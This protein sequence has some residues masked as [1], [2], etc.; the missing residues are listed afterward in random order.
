MGKLGWQGCP[1][2]G[3]SSGL[4][5]VAS[6]LSLPGAPPCWT[7][8]PYPSWKYKMALPIS[9]SG[10][11]FS[12]KLSLAKATSLAFVNVLEDPQRMTFYHP[13]QSSVLQLHMH[14]FSFCKSVIC[15]ENTFRW[16]SSGVYCMPNKAVLQGETSALSYFVPN[17]LQINAINHLCTCLL[18]YLFSSLLSG[19]CQFCLVTC[20]LGSL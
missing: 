10:T 3:R 20:T 8:V 9:C 13:Y 11:C 16:N 4:A 1:M 14:V 12:T 18:F 17:L 6:S 15:T 7:A 5:V 19:L 2:A